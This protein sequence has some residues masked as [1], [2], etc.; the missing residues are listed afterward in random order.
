M[1]FLILA[2]ILLASTI[3]L[4]LYFLKRK[5]VIYKVKHMS[6]KEKVDVVNAA[7][8]P[9]GFT[10]DSKQDIV[11][12]KN[13]SWQRDLGY[14]DFFDLK[15]PLLNMVMD[16]E[17]IYFDYDNKHYRI[18]FWK[19]QYGITTGAEAGIYIREENKNHYRSANDFEQLPMQFALYKKCLLFSR[20]GFT[21]W[22]TG[23]SVGMFS[24]PKD[25]MLKVTIYFP[26]QE[27][28]VAFVEGLLNA[29]YAPK[30]IA[31]FGNSICFSICTPKNYK[32][33]H[34]HKILKFFVQIINRMNCSFYMWI[35]RPF[36]STLDKLTYLRFMFPL[37]YH[38][39][40]KIS[41]PRRKYKK[42]CKKRKKKCKKS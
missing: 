39:I 2:F 10:F 20:C 9:F 30:H 40:I 21:W 7:L 6:E 37:L 27:M 5:R 4:V 15:A 26:N 33:N 22:L 17:P 42:Y 11:I 29:G 31:V 38:C 16:A 24:R 13:D 8:H 1:K 35:T 34:G 25:L 18:E 14:S 36:N 3:L 23:F 41:I 19:G 32:L 28:Q 12:S